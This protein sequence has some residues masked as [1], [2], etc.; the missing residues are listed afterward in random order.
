VTI[1]F[2]YLYRGVSN[3]LYEKTQGRLVPK[4]PETFAYCFTSG[5]SIASGEGVCGTSEVN[6]VIRHQLDQAG[7]PTSG[8]STTP[9]FA[10]ARF[11]ALGGGAYSVG[12]VCKLDRELF[13]LNHVRE[14]VV[15]EYTVRPA[16][17]QDDEVIL[18]AADTGELP[19]GVTVEV[20]RVT[21]ST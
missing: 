2:R 8:I 9:H 11:Y 14:F 7:F 20:I 18:V 15:A 21:D 3:E 19:R 12:Y 16:V 1:P 13:A 17:P 5:E 10:R 4:L 6:A